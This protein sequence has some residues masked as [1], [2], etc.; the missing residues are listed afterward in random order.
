MMDANETLFQKAYELHHERGDIEGAVALY[1]EV[2]ERFPSS[3]AA[4][5]A[6]DQLA[7]IDEMSE[8]ELDRAAAL[9]RDA[10]ADAPLP[11]DDPGFGALRVLGVAFK[12]LAIFNLV[13]GVVTALV[14]T[15]E[16][17]I[18]ISGLVAVLGGAFSALVCWALAE[19]IRALLTI[20]E[21]T[22]RTARLLSRQFNGVDEATVT[23]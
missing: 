18:G 14:A 23:D 20:E 4:S 22:R 7:V 6:A 5:R 12:I 17:D 1:R 8:E 10:V 19:A 9:A 21:N 16:P 3:E 15:A 2:V 13:A 11:D